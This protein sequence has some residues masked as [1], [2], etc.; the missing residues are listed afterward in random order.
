M[1]TINRRTLNH[2]LGK[3]LDTV[4]E[5]GEPIRVEGRDGRAVTIS[6]APKTETTWERW[7]RTGQVKI[8]PPE[9]HEQWRARWDSYRKLDGVDADWLIAEMAEDH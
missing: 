5:T 1:E 3:I 6:A 2:N 4:L 9:P 7:V 8:G